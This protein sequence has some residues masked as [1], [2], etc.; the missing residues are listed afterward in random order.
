[1]ELFLPL[2]GLCS[3][4]FLNKIFF[5]FI[6]EIKID[7]HHD[8]ELFEEKMDFQASE[9][10][11][12]FNQCYLFSPRS[13]KLILKQEMKLS[14]QDM[15]LVLPLPGLWSKIFYYKYFFHFYQGG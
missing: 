7:F 12:Y 6:K 11:I 4:N 2:Q 13:S 8:I 10:N 5:I 9:Q 15:E 1:M 3:K 14:N